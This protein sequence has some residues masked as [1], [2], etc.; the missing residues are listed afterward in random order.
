[1]ASILTEYRQ[2]GGDPEMVTAEQLDVTYANLTN[3]DVENDIA[4]IE[5]LDGDPV[6]YV[7]V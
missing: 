7:R 1:M 6:G 3:C 2:Y 5:T 4:L